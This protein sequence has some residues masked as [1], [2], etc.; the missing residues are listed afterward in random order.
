[1]LKLQCQIWN[2]LLVLQWQSGQPTIETGNS[3][4]KIGGQQTLRAGLLPGRMHQCLP[5]PTGPAY[6][7]ATA[8]TSLV[9]MV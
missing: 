3:S 5:S 4:S 2:G 8:A 7:S 6:A 1:M 9:C